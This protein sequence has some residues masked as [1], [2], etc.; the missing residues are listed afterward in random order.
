[1]LD[2]MW[3]KG[4]PPSLLVG[5]SIGTM[6]MENSIEIPHKTKCRATI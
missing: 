4:N 5:M 6:P 1:M 3:K 2:R